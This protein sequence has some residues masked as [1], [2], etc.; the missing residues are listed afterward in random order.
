MKIENRKVLSINYKELTIFQRYLAG[1][2]DKS[3]DGSPLEHEVRELY[4]RSFSAFQTQTIDITD[5][6]EKKVS[7]HCEK[8]GII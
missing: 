7:F 5:L 4:T 3:F 8:A 1:V 6:D 2:W